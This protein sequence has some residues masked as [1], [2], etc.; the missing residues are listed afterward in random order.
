MDYDLLVLF[1]LLLKCLSLTILCAFPVDVQ[2]PFFVNSDDAI[3][4][5]KSESVPILFNYCIASAVP[6]SLSL[7]EHLHE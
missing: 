7:V 2:I 3:K 4:R 1:M 6:I 5:F